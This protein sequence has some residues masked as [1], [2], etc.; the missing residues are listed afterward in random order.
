VTDV[1]TRGQRVAE[2]RPLTALTVRALGAA[3]RQWW[4]SVENIA[5]SEKAWAGTGKGA[6]GWPSPTAGVRE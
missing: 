2:H 6:G 3:R 1:V 5:G 4:Q